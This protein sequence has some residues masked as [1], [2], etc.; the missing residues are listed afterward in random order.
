MSFALEEML[1][2]EGGIEWMVGC[3][4]GIGPGNVPG[5]RGHEYG[6]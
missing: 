5:Q 1:G 2:V 3:G 4:E 6:G